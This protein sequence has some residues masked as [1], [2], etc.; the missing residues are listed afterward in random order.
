[1]LS[2]YP[3]TFAVKRADLGSIATTTTFTA[4]ATDIITAAAISFEDGHT[5]TVSTTGTLPA[6]LAASTTYYTVSSSGTTC[7]LSLTLGGTEIDITDTGA[8]THTIVY[9]NYQTASNSFKYKY[10]FTVASDTLALNNVYS[11]SGYSSTIREYEIS[12]HYLNTNSTSVYTSY[13]ALIAESVYPL[14]FIDY[15]KYKLA[16]DLCFNLTGDTQLLELLAIQ[17]KKMLK[18]A[19]NVDAKQNMART[20]KSSPFTQIRGSSGYSPSSGSV[21]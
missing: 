12:N 14:Y 10:N 9:T 17:E 7:K 15:F 3:W 13:T 8:G 21:W 16:M 6:G 18:S 19:K 11:D 1:M 4:A 2:N 5:C 20:I